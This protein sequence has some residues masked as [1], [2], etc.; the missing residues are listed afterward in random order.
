MSRLSQIPLS[1]LD[2]APIS[3]DG[4]PAETFERTVDL[5]QLTDTLGYNR[6]WLAEHHNIDG[7]ASAATSLL[8]GHV[9]SKT[10]RIR[11]G[12]GGIMLPNHPP[13]VVAEQ[14]G[15]LETLYP[16]RIDLGLGRA[17]GSDGVTMQAMRRNPRAGVNDFPDRLAELRGY[18]GDARPDQRVKAI[19]GQGTHVPLWLL[20]SSDF[21]A[22]LAAQLGLPFVFA[23]QF[24]PGYMLEAIQLYRQ[25]FQPSDVLDAPYVMLGI[26]LVAADSDAH[27]QYLATTQQQ[28]FLNLI[29]GKSTRTLPPVEALDWS[30]QERAMVSQNLGASIVGGPDTIRD[31]LERFLAHTQADELMINGD[32][33]DHD[34][35]RRSYEILADVWKG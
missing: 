34:D 16:G 22:R 19:P 23:G 31:E 15:T 14:F 9:A 12:S 11:V 13:L 2:L 20:G 28:K 7:I 21:S 26:P 30:P 17:P 1:V 27:A 24:A 4:T 25:M 3:H 33:Y 18:L 10:Q 29:R 8:I 32:F 5:A 35:R 6:Y